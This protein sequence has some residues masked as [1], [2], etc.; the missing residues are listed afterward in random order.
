[1][2]KCG[3][4]LYIKRVIIKTEGSQKIKDELPHNE[5]PG[6]RRK[7]MV[8]YDVYEEKVRGLYKTLE[9]AGYSL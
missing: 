1:M 8:R 9:E 7:I 2:T 3:V 4:L 6:K 5:R